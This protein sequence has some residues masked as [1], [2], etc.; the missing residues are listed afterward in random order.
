MSA[1]IITELCQNHNGDRKLLQEM[2]HA[3]AENGADIVKIQTI[4]SKELTHRPEFDE[5]SIIDGEVNIIKRP[6]KS[7]YERLKKLDLKIEDESWFIQECLKYGVSPMTTVFTKAGL[8]EI[9]DLGYEAIKIA[10]YDCAS[11]SLLK[12]VKKSFSK[13]FISTG[14]T[15]DHE[16]E[17]AAKILKGS[18]FEFL[19]CVTIY[20]TPL[21]ELHLSRINHLRKYSSK[22]GYS[23]HSHVKNT[24]IIAS[25]IAL[26][27]GASCIERHFT[28]LKDDQTKDGPVSISPIELKQ[29][30]DFNKLSRFEQIKEINSQMPNWQ[31]TVL[32]NPKRELSKAELINRSYY[33]GRFASHV[34]G[35]TIYN[36]DETQV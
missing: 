1:K 31:H 10:S 16:I 24:G 12:E 27:L 30:S 15:Y 13:I 5:G 8:K 9:K 33:R 29:L 23:D 4:R 6:Y 26:G 18:D 22:V 36:W 17:K 14:A 28:I 34:D 35:K 25:K 21:E 20:P 11:Y 19:H 7:E 3:S 2:I 32:G